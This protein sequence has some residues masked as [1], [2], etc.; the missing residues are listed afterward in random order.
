MPKG[1]GFQFCAPLVKYQYRGLH[2][3][4]VKITTSEDSTTM[5][6]YAYLDFRVAPIFEGPF[7]VRSVEGDSAACLSL[8]CRLARC[9][10]LSSYWVALR[11]LRIRCDW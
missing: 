5:P 7:P 3:Y 2:D 9:L 8:A 6:Y 1:W 10:R 4:L 11:E